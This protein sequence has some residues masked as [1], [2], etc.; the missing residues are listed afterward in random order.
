MKTVLFARVSSRDQ[1]ET[2]YSL[3][4]Q[5]KLL[6]EY[7]E[8]KGFN[9]AKKFSISE[10]ASG[11]NQRKTFNEM[12]NYIK[13]N[14]IKII[15]C[16]KVD[17]LTRNLKDAVS[18]N[19]WIQQDTERQVHFVKESCV[20][21]KDS[22]S[23]DKFIWNIKI[24]V[25]Q[26][27]IDNL[28]EEVKKG[29]KEKIA[30]GWLPS[31][32]PLGYKT[33]GESKHK[34][35]IIDNDKAPL[36][37][38]MF[39]LYASGNYSLNKLADKM[40]D[41]GLRSK[42]GYKLHKSGIVD[43]LSNPFYYGKI[44]WQNEIY[45]GKQEPLINKELFDQIQIV[46][47]RKTTPKYN[48]H[49]YLFNGLINCAECDGLITWEIQKGI[50]YGHC[51]H[52][53]N[54]SQKV[55]AKEKDLETKIIEVFNNLQ[56]KN[57]RLADWINK[58]LK[59]SHK[60]EID[61][62]NNIIN[63]LN[64]RSATI[65]KRLDRLYDDKL[66]E[67]IT[68]D[69]YKRKFQQY[70]EEK[71]HIIKSLSDHSQANSKYLEMGVN[72]Y[73]LSQRASELY[74]KANAQEKRQLINHVLEKITL[75]NGHLSFNYT[76]S[77]SILLNTINFANSSKVIKLAKTKPKIFE[78]LKYGLNKAKDRT[79]H[80]VCSALQSLLRKARTFFQKNC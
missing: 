30:Q 51:N 74:L 4:S 12:L 42:N 47:H 27:Y 35:H 19:D 78:P 50:V 18:I 15:V 23:N 76:K 11:S 25:A 22:K 53:R 33:V 36:I 21:N 46:A 69:M 52:Y 40:Y 80:P 31:K 39:E 8:R 16:E 66:D 58:A 77:F 60:E 70:T 10:S 43:L 49:F 32:P 26:Y 61:Y 63:D 7:A 20:L 28:S 67:I 54:C 24:S 13:N 5:E 14:N 55:Y 71:D 65:Q 75:D 57:T 6:K 48:K 56:I 79:L 37:I 41:E 68:D 59:E 64:S 45:D 2:G 62:H 34:I 38:K 73:E 44:V 17:R 3:P 9:V 29:Q 72:I 1:E